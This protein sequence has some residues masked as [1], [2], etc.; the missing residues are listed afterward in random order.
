MTMIDSRLGIQQRVFAAYRQP[1]FEKL[2]AECAQGFSLFAGSARDDEHI[3]AAD[4]LQHGTY[5]KARNRHLFSG[6]MYLCWQSGLVDWVNSF[7]PHILI[8]EA[9]PRYINLVQGINAVHAHG[10]KVIGWGLGSPEVRGLSGLLVNLLRQ[11]LYS[12]LDA[13]ITYSQ[14]GAD[15]YRAAGFSPKRVFVAPNAAVDRQDFPIPERPGGYYL[16]QPTVLFVGRLQERKR[17]DLLIQACSRLQSGIK[18]R[19]WIVGEGPE[20]QALET[21][22]QSTAADVTFFGSKFGDELAYLFKQADLFV[23]PGTGGLALQQAMSYGLPVIAA[24]ADGTQLELVRDSNGWLM[25]PGNL[26]VLT[27]LISEA[28]SEVAS[29][30]ARGVESYRIVQDEINLS[31]M[32]AVFSEAAAAV[33]AGI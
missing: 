14:K 12:N 28:L 24:E 30:R 13:M 20:R 5:I 8:V 32:V 15:E 10:G 1:F 2:A 7:R 21:Q 9:N 31:H 19:L 23:L 11:R 3:P 4:S 22:A 27:S 29:L 33:K 6:G 25:P 17:V 16:G 26:D 18:P